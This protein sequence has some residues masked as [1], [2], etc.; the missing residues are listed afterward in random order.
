MT[1]NLTTRTYVN[2]TESR[3]TFIITKG[4]IRELSSTFKA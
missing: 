4:T 3:I 1:N 2:G